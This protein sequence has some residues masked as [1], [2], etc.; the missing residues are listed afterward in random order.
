MKDIVDLKVK[1]RAR[2]AHTRLRVGVLRKT[3]AQSFSGAQTKNEYNKRMFLRKPV[4]TLALAVI[5]TALLLS[6]GCAKT[7]TPPASPS[8]EVNVPTVAV[9]TATATLEPTP[10]EIP[11]AAIVNGEPI[12]LNYFNNEVWR[13]RDSLANQ[14][15]KPDDATI[16]QT[17][18]N[19]LI[20]QQLLA[21]E[22]HKAGF[23]LSGA[24]LQ[25]KI[26]NLVA[27][28]GSG[29]AFT[30]WMSNNHYDDAEFRMALT[31]ASDAAWQRDQISAT[32]PDA[33]EQVRARQIF[34]LTPEGAQRAMTSLAS[35]TDFGTLAWE[36]SPESGGELGWF[37]RGYLLYP[38][39]EAAAFSLEVGGRSE[40]IQSAIGYHIIEVQAHEPAHPLTTDARIALQTKALQD[41][42]ANA[43]A[44][45]QI[46]I[47]I[48]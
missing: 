38:E 45:S 27:G 24:D 39:V 37:P 13:Y 18:I 43:I 7:Q 36:Y 48:P 19:Y 11:A 26:D 30:D 46:V 5:T 16:N 34:A 32:V 1:Y 8:P 4:T 25:V 6:A 33:V 20:E 41:W 17:V 47:Q 28:L 3:S 40:I 9:S 35:G 44:N 31:L 12:P 10:T 42:L 22:A 14:E 29:S 2:S 15:V 23:T 21:Q